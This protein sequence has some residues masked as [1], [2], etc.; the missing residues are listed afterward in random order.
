MENAIIQ[1]AQHV[2]LQEG[3]CAAIEL[4]TAFF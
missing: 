3:K 1:Q 4:V 2:D